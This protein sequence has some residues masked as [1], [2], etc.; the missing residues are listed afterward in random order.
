[1]QIV[2]HAIIDFQRLA[3]RRRPWHAALALA[4]SSVGTPAL[5][6][7]LALA[8]L[9]NGHAGCAGALM[10]AGLLA[11]LLALLA[12]RANLAKLG[13][14][15]LIQHC[16]ILDRCCV[17][18]SANARVRALARELGYVSVIMLRQLALTNAAALVIIGNRLLPT[19]C[20]TP[21]IKSQRPN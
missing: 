16:L 20:I 6:L 17:A 14:W 18:S 8:A 4:S 12:S 13:W 9:H 10:L 7:H 21:R 5:L 15:G 3:A 19:A 2:A 1:M 11:G